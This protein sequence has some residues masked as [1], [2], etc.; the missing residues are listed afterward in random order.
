MN[1]Q[2][3]ILL[4]VF[5]LMIL[6]VA[7][8]SATPLTAV[9]GTITDQNNA[10]VA[11]ATVTVTCD[12]ATPKTVSSGADGKYYAFFPAMDCGVDAPV[13]VHAQLG[14]AQGDNEGTVTYSGT[15]KI[16]MSLVN[17]QIPE[18]R[19][20]AGGIALIGAI[21]GFAVLRKKN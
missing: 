9:S 16:N 19:V 11:G 18:F 13:T 20:I 7:A 1:K 5:A 10:V 8:V 4:S 17:V 3:G 15:C 14:D 6:S 12:G 2:L 21:A